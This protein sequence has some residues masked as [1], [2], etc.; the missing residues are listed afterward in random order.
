MGLREIFR[1]RLWR[2]VRRLREIKYS[3]GVDI[4]FRFFYFLSDENVKVRI[5]LLKR[6]FI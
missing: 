2:E 5:I 6:M 4:Y 1:V 3:E